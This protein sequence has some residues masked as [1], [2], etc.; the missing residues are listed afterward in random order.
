MLIDYS[1]P[2]DE[3]LI[4][5]PIDVSGLEDIYVVGEVSSERWRSFINCENWDPK[6]YNDKLLGKRAY[7]ARCAYEA[8]LLLSYTDSNWLS[9]STFE[10]V[11][12]TALLELRIIE[13]ELFTYQATC[14]MLCWVLEDQSKLYLTAG[15]CYS[16]LIWMADKIMFN[17]K[18]KPE[19]GERE[20]YVA[21]KKL[22][23]YS[24][25]TSRELC[26]QIDQIVFAMKQFLSND[27]RRVAVAE[28]YAKELLVKLRNCILHLDN[29]VK[30]TP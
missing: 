3:P 28:N 22:R 19:K 6:Q 29:V 20:D 7:A 16:T 13:F 12:D 1:V 27:M 2:E 30:I 23:P 10:L 21:L 4:P 14:G 18:L 17:K 15:V 25:D 8:C 26:R 5:G 11:R 9:V 24:V